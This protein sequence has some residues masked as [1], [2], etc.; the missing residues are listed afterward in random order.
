MIHLQYQPGIINITGWFRV[1]DYRSRTAYSEGWLSK[2]EKLS[3]IL[4]RIPLNEK[5]KK[6]IDRLSAVEVLVVAVI[7]SRLDYCHC[8]FYNMGKSNTYISQK[9]QNA[10]ARLLARKR[11]RWDIRGVEKIVLVRS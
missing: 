3:K 11:K 10:T 6:I 5:N 8:M 1:V 2:P 9:V 7:S 4:H